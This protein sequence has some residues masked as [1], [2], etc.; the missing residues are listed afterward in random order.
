MTTK[1]KTTWRAMRLGD[2][3]N[4]NPPVSLERGKEYPFMDMANVTPLSRTTNWLERKA[5]TGS[6]ARF[7]EGD[8]LFARITPCLEN[9]KITQAVRIGGPGF[10]STEFYVLRGKKKVSDSDFIF[11]LTRTYRIRKLA[12]ASMLGASGRQRVERAAFEN[13]EVKAPEDVDEQ[14]RIARVLAAFDEKIENNNRIIKA[15]EEIVQMVFKEWFVNFHFPSHKKAEFVDSALGRIPKGW[16]V[17][18]LGDVIELT[19]GKALKEENRKSGDVVVVG[20]S[21]IVG[22]HNQKLVSGPGIVVGRKGV[23]GSVIWVDDDFYPIDTTF[24]VKT[25]LPLIFC[26]LM[27]KRQNFITGDSAVPGLNREDAQ[28]NMVLKPDAKAIEQFQQIADTM[29]HQ[30]FHLEKENQ[31]LAVTRDLLLPRLMSGEIRV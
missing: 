5:F 30:K 11:Y 10:G 24:Y 20:S 17:K 16:E 19:Y 28:R 12:E 7:D 1:T 26:F 18:T 25:K 3:A 13:I 22:R 29:F 27:L 15:L 4:V 14:K 31:K 2:F 23:A 6:G 8:T 21:G 9:G